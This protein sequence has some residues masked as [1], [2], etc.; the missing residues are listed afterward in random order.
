MVRTLDS[1]SSNPSSNLGGTFS[2][3]FRAYIIS[4]TAVAVQSRSQWNS[5]NKL[6]PTAIHKLI[7]LHHDTAGGVPL[8]RSSFLLLSVLFLRKM[9]DETRRRIEENV[10]EVLKKSSME[11]TTEFKVRSQ[12]EERL[13]IDLSNK[14][15]KLL[16]RNVVESFLLSMSERVCMGKEDEP[17]PSVRYENKAVEQK[18]VPKKEFNDDGD[19]LICR[20]K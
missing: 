7:V 2:F 3:F 18:I 19:L 17:G 13:G 11:D 12:V 15:C 8:L 9:N 14:Q 5:H 16:V 6:N 4:S 20:V 10:I 1:E